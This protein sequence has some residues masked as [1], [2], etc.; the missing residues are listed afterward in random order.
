MTKKSATI[1]FTLVLGSLFI[2]SAPVTMA[3]PPAKAV[4]E[5]VDYFYSGQKD[6][7]IL[8]DSKLCKSI[9]TLECE[10][11]INPMRFNWAI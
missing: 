10:Q 7:P 4:K 3:A 5:V 1:V 6:G 2:L 8:T 9:K 11:P